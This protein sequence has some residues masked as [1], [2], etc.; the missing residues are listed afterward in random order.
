MLFGSD[1]FTYPLLIFNTTTL[2]LVFTRNS[3]PLSISF[4]RYKRGKYAE[5]RLLRD[6]RRS[7]RGA[8][9][10]VVRPSDWVADDKTPKPEDNHDV[11]LIALDQTTSQFLPS[12]SPVSLRK[13]RLRFAL[14]LLMLERMLLTRVWRND[15][16]D[17]VK[18][19]KHA[20]RPSPLR[21]EW[22]G[23]RMIPVR[24]WYRETTRLPGFPIRS[25][26]PTKTGDCKRND[27]MRVFTQWRMYSSMDAV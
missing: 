26:A 3:S 24:L 11:I 5:L 7:W 6:K 2:T 23:L 18:L 8:S 12:S 25:R 10:A 1:R 21:K 27:G 15:N 16:E 14:T 4:H 9:A 22:I 13:F 19:S 17:V 20:R